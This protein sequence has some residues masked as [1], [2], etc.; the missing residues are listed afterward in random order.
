MRFHMVYSFRYTPCGVLGGRLL[1]DRLTRPVTARLTHGDVEALR[2]AAT[3]HQTTVSAEIAK[4]VR[5]AVHGDD[6]GYRDGH[7]DDRRAR[8]EDAS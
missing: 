4:A 1:K 6:R 3:Q 2:R 8:P 7:Q 5:T